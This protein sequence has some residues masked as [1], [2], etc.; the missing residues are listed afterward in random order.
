MVP[1]ARCVPA[2]EAACKSG[3]ATGMRR[4]PAPGIP[5]ISVPARRGMEGVGHVWRRA[6]FIV[7]RLP[8]FLEVAI[9]HAPPRPPPSWGPG[10]RAT[11]PAGEPCCGGGG[12]APAGLDLP[13]LSRCLVLR[14]ARL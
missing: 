12:S 14:V 8:P 11:P 1:A 5:R 3:S 2:D 9:P 13:L 10:H 4:A 6:E 7:A